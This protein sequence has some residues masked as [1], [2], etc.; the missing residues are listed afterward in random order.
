MDGVY[1]GLYDKGHRWIEG[2]QKIWVNFW[3]RESLFEGL[4]SSNRLRNTN[5]DLEVLR[6]GELGCEQSIVLQKVND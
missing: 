6:W 2:G 3:N 5:T 4:L 1:R